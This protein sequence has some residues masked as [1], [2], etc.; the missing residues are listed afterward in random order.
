MK[1]KISSNK[2]SLKKEWIFWK[3]RSKYTYNRVKCVL[4]YKLNFRQFNKLTYFC[5]I[6]KNIWGEHEQQL[7]YTQN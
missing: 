2:K 7:W 6:K 4:L 1:I 3:L 5:I